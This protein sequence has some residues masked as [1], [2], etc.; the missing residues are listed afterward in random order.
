M[1][2]GLR[3][4][5]GAVLGALITLAAHPASRPFIL[6]ATANVTPK[7]LQKLLDED[8]SSLHP[9]R[10]LL[11]AALWI[12]LGY[13]KLEDG[14][15]LTPKEVDSLIDVA[16]AAA[17]KDSRNA[18]WQQS[19]AVLLLQK[20]QRDQSLHAWERASRTDYWKD[21]QSDRLLQTQRQLQRETGALQAW[22]YAVSFYSRSMSGGT[23]I[24]TVAKSLLRNLDY[25]SDGAR[26]IRYATLMNGNLLRIGG[27]SNEVSLHGANLV[28]LAA[29]PSSLTSTPSPKRLWTGQ[30]ELLTALR[31]ADER[32]RFDS[33]KAAFDD[34]ESWRALVF[35]DVERRNPETI[36]SLSIG[37]AVTPIATVAITIA[38]LIAWALGK[39]VGNI[40]KTAPKFPIVGVA[41][42]AGSLALLVFFLSR[43]FA[44]T[45]AVALSIG[46]LLVTP[47]HV[48]QTTKADL[49]PLFTFVMLCISVLAATALAAFVFATSAPAIALAPQL[50]V[51]H[52]YYER[53]GLAGLSA[54]FLSFIFIACPLY[55]LVHRLP[56]PAVVSTGLRRAG[57]MMAIGGLLAT[58]VLAPLCVYFDRGLCSQLSR[59][60]SNEPVYHL[61]Q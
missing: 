60:L 26:A 4:F 21:Y 34:T 47:K 44:A 59:L 46:F 39:S 22:Q 57:A 56:T 13:D 54:V 25:Q 55:A 12:Q 10:N 8:A 17:E 41:I 2:P 11:D 27:R 9:P 24:E 51:P 45:L 48:R 3:A 53:P 33:A 49:G 6:G 30:N 14:R 43:N 5:L 52:S 16:N 40:L 19:L 38:G 23:Q 15:G 29:Y 7:E 28:E 36:A 42:A 35:G 31:K 37:T 32:F 58:V 20:G 50:G 1:T 18:F 61:T